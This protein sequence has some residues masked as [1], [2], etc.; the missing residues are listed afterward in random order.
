MR[1]SAAS[2]LTVNNVVPTLN[3]LAATT[4]NENQ[5]TTLTGN[6]LEPGTLD[7]LILTINWGD[8]SSPG[9][10]QVIN[11]ATGTASF[12]VTH[13]Y[14]DDNPSATPSDDYTINVAV[15][16]DDAGTSNTNTMVTVNN[17]APALSGLSG[18]T[19]NGNRVTTSAGAVP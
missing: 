6:I 3:G 12:N 11:L 4:I 16:D 18:S 2:T 9:N 8:P 5:F 13:Q 7:P 17:V 15:A 19:M 10:I 1:S 14:L